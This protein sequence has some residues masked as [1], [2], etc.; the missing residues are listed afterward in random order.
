MRRFTL[1]L[2]L[3]LITGINSGLLAQVSITG[4]V[5]AEVIEVL[6]ATENTALNFGSFSPEAGG[7]TITITPDGSRLSLGTIGMGKSLHSPAS[8]LVSGEDDA[9]FSISLPTSP[10][11]IINSTGTKTMNV[12]NWVASPTNEQGLAILDGGSK[13]VNVG[14]TLNVGTMTEN[15]KGMYSGTYTI[16]FD[17]N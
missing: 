12:S 10:V 1:V 4:S 8:F 13:I 11:S 9:S 16:V 17:Y 14:A 7:G 5:Y 3:F 15:P 6:S 2:S